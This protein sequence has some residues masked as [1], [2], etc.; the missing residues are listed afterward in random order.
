MIEAL[1]LVLEPFNVSSMAQAAGCASL[2][3]PEQVTR[4]RRVNEEGKAFLYEQFDAM[5]VTYVPT[6]ANFIFLDPGKH[7][8]EVFDRMMRRGV[9]VRTGDIWGWDT[10][11]RATIGTRAENERFLAALRYALSDG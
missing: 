4:S 2:R 1:K 9:T 6:Q 7:S 3:D 5:G 8:A 10:W 11:I